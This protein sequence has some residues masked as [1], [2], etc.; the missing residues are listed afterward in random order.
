MVS[1][2][3]DCELQSDAAIV[4]DEVWLR[5]V[6]KVLLITRTVDVD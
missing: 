4:V 2:D 5:G 6:V 3:S 1:N